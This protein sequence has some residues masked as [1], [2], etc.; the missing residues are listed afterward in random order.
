L[1]LHHGAPETSPKLKIFPSC[2]S[3]AG[4]FVPTQIRAIDPPTFR[5]ARPVF[6]ISQLLHHSAT[7]PH[8]CV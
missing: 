4:L 7:H 6:S 3:V 5:T 8:A 2:L 1:D